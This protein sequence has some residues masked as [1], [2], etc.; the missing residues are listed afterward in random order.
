MRI[1]R[2]SVSNHRRTPDI[3]VDIREHA[4]FVGPNGVGKSTVLRL[5]DA[6]LGSSWNQLVASLDV[7]HLRDGANPLQVEVRLEGLDADDLAHFADKVEVG[8]GD[9]IDTVWL[10]ARLVATVSTADPERLDITRAFVKP[11]VADSTIT[12]DD[13]RLIGWTFLPANRSP[14]R[15]IGGGRA[16]VTRALLQA[17]ALDDVEATA[18]KDAVASLS[19]A[20]RLSPSLLGV[21]KDLA[22]QLSLL[23][24]DPIG[25]DDL[26]VDLPSSTIEQPLNDVDIQL[27][28][29]GTRSP[30]SSQS[31]G[32]RSLS[33]V[34]VQLLARR[35]ARILA[36]DE[37]E[38]HLHPRGQANL[39]GLLATAPGQRLVATHAPAVLAEFLP[40]HAIAITPTGGR[41][42]PAGSL[43]SD[44][45]VLHNWWI[46]SVLEPLTAMRVIFVEGAS[47][48]IVVK[49]VA[50]I[51]GHDLDRSG[52]AVVA[53]HGSGNF[54]R[55]LALFGPSG[56]NIRSLGLVDE[57]EAIDPAAG[58]GV[59]VAD[60]LNHDVLICHT[61]LED[62][63]VNALGVEQTVKL[64][65]TSRLF[66]E[67][68]IKTA[69]R[70]TALT[71]VQPSELATEVLRK[72]KVEAA[73]ALAEG[74]SPAQAAS[75]ATVKDLVERSV[76]P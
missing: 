60:L 18:I 15:D 23:L 61:D 17:L 16:S 12:R 37:P 43:E 32:L 39:A 30:L 51:L 6:L 55:A 58:L 27:D 7:S 31:D 44:K 8:T 47:D 29:E 42:L 68:Q 62:E 63:Y 40:S 35:S 3:D 9:A 54:R 20:L 64:L 75:I 34:A 76:A 53:L 28:R 69:T 38:I 65:L 56:F 19:T 11:R 36:I 2:I 57:K 59:T 72:N 4:V 73:V 50:R 1:S 45:K 66:S 33:V 14:D 22:K 21:R 74:M 26:A 25:E 10:T 24:P 46:D 70:R 5:V 52:I 67:S 49:A 71:D 13:L 41:Q 48:R